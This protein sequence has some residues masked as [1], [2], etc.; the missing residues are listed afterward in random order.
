MNLS[1]RIEYYQK[2]YRKKLKQYRKKLNANSI[3]TKSIEPS[4]KNGVYTYTIPPAP[5]G[6]INAN[7]IKTKSIEPSLKNGVY[8][9]TIPPA[10][11]GYMFD[12]ITGYMSITI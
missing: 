7:S 10:P 5:D 2:K 8:T 4:L 1:E 9:Y 11:D 6:Y 12:K 3:K